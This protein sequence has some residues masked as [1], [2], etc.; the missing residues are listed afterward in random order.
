[1]RGASSGGA[2]L[3]LGAKLLRIN[4]LLLLLVGLLAGAGFLML[5]S[6]ADG[7]LDPWA[8]R[9][10]VRFAAGSAIMIGL[11]LVD[12]RLLLRHAYTIYGLVLAMLVAVDLAGIMGMGARRWLDL[13]PVA[14]QPSELMKVTLVLALARLYHFLD[15]GQVNRLLW[16]LPPL[17]L[18]AVPV[19]LVLEQPDLG[20]A[21]MISAV[22]AAMLFLAGVAVWKFVAAGLGAAAL[23]PIAW[24]MLH[25][26]Q[27]RRVLTFLD[28]DQDPLGAGYH[29]T[30]SKIA[31]GSGGMFGK[32]FLNGT[33]AQLDFLPEKHTDFIFT[34][35]AEE[36]GMMGCLFVLALYALVI[37]ICFATGLRS[38]SQFG[39]LLALGVGCMLFFYVFINVGMVMGLL[40]VVGVPLP[41]ISYGGTAMLTVQLGLG[42]VLS[43]AVH[44]DVEI[45]RGP[46]AM[47]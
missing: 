10:M 42:L 35:L 36:F 9:Q 5:Y 11:A 37:A 29:I 46:G 28:P 24:S 1:M 34:M 40:P 2:A 23:V 31:L 39:R 17:L 12:I 6:A 27:R 15:D 25:D 13:G 16:H 7:R 14:L 26:Y 3:G 38:R 32:G 44:Q 20:T 45:G 18:I 30:Q 22:G 47:D 21:V 43:A 41:L 4:W 8:G 19:G 33:Q